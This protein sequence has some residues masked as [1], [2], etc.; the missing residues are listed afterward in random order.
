MKLEEEKIE[1]ILGGE[2]K[3]N[4][5]ARKF[6]SSSLIVGDLSIWDYIRFKLYFTMNVGMKELRW[7][8]EIGRKKDRKNFGRRGEVE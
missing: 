6:F 5:S 7:K 1:R 4:G 3:W 2:E 8:V